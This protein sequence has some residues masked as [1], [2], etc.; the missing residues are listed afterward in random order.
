MRKRTEG[1]PWA[2]CT[3]IKKLPS[4]FDIPGVLSQF[5]KRHAD[6]LL[7]SIPRK[8]AANFL[9]FLCCSH[10]STSCIYIFINF[11]KEREFN[12]LLLKTVKPSFPFWKLLTR[13]WCCVIVINVSCRRRNLRGLWTETWKPSYFTRPRSPSTVFLYFSI[14]PS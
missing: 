4:P 7:E 6:K 2:E 8:K 13:R 14:F 3:L 11:G 10:L 1:S 9:K 5:E 12:S